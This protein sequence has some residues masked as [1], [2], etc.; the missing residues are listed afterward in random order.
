M[1][2]SKEQI[3]ASL[4]A[5]GVSAPRAAA[6]AAKAKPCVRLETALLAD[7]ES[8]PLGATRIGGH[9]DLP[10]GMGWPYRKPYP[11]AAD[12]IAETEATIENIRAGNEAA[13]AKASPYASSREKVE[14]QAKH[15]IDLIAPVAEPRPLAFVAQIDLVG[16][17]AVQ[18]LDPDLPVS[19]RLLFFYDAQQQPWGINPGDSA[20]WSVLYD[21]TDPAGLERL[22]PP[23]SP[24]PSGAATG[25]A[26]LRC[27]GR[28]EWSPVPEDQVLLAI[29]DRSDPDRARLADWYG[30]RY[31]KLLDRRDW[32]AHQAGGHPDQIQDGQPPGKRGEDWVLLMQIDSDDR[33]SMTWGDSGMLY[34]WIRRDDLRARQFDRAWVVLQS[35]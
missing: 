28:A 4:W 32:H 16:I 10:A 21:I 3:E 2:T 13:L 24:G 33:I 29:P 31:G 35:L 23:R 11:D 30:D 19:G 6:L 20:G 18:S 26:A 1:F 9:P 12:R 5:A 15:L 27:H 14:A 22:T 8:I 17:Q 7:G 25:F 34:V